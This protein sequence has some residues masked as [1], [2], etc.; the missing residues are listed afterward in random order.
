M[1]EPTSER[2]YSPLTLDLVT[3]S[4]SG[5][6]GSYKPTLLTKEEYLERVEDAIRDYQRIVD[7]YNSRIKLL[8]S[9]AADVGK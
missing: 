9:L 7:D 2:K 8:H 5:A 6:I 1:S 4:G 3:Q